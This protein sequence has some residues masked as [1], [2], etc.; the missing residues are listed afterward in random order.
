M[1]FLLRSQKM[2]RTPPVRADGSRSVD[3]F[4]TLAAQGPGAHEIRIAIPK[5]CF[6]NETPMLV[7]RQGFSPNVM[8]STREEFPT[9]TG[10]F[11]RPMAASV[12]RQ[13]YIFRGKKLC[14]N[15]R[16]GNNDVAMCRHSNRGCQHCRHPSLAFLRT[17]PRGHRSMRLPRLI[18][19]LSAGCVVLALDAC[20]PDVRLV[21][22]SLPS[23]PISEMFPR[24]SSPPPDC[25]GQYRESL[26][27]H[28]HSVFLGCWGSK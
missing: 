21:T 16:G 20:R 1:V 8:R 2:I 18:P 11:S 17:S 13:C 4:T 7:R 22:E 23:H 10:N 28:G 25:P 26:E 6:I 3:A 5:T 9:R 12:R 27:D 15:R 14:A 24:A 19:W